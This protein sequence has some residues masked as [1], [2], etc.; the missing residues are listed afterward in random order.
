MCN[1]KGDKMANKTTNTL[2]LAYAAQGAVFICICSWLVIP[3]PVPFTM[4]TFGVFLVL[5]TGAEKF[6]TKSILTY[7]F[8][9]LVGLP[10][11]SGFQ[12]GPGVLFGLTGGYIFGFLSVALVYSL[13]IKFLGKNSVVEIGSMIA[14]LILC[15]VVGTFWFVT[16]YSNTGENISVANALMWC[17]VPF[18]IPDMI[19]MIIA[20]SISKKLRVHLK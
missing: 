20:Y 3:G 8:L 17:V 13:G 6:G 16:A 10:V 19:K 12:A 2:Q 4:Q 14:G 15:Y 7:I 9:G 5:F 18:V 11:F 1:K